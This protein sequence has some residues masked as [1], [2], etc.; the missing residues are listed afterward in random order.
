MAAEA[1]VPG[2]VADPLHVARMALTEIAVGV[3]TRAHGIHGEV[4]VD[5]RTDEPERRFTPGTVL[6]SESTDRARGS[7]TT[8]FTV[9]RTRE[10]QGRWLVTFAEI[11]DRTAAEAVRGARLIAEIAEDERPT[12][13][14]EYYDRQL[15]GLTVV[16]EPD[17]RIGTVRSVLHLPAQDVLEIDTGSGVRLVPFVTELVPDVDLDAGRIV[18]A[19]VAGLLSDTEPPGSTDGA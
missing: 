19:D 10:H 5:L 3:I 6:R 7:A 14:D 17:D 13:K 12:G 4:V 18:V 16:V 15:V 2:P 8:A 1:A 9:V 11:P